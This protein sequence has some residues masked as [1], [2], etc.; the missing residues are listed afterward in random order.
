MAKFK[1]GKLIK[2]SI[3]NHGYNKFLRLDGTLDVAINEDKI[4]FDQKWDGLKGYI[5]HST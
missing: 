1:S 2:R 3:N 5:T 4:I